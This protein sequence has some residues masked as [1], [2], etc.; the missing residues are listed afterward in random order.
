MNNTVTIT[1]PKGTVSKMVERRKSGDAGCVGDESIF[2][3]WIRRY[4][5]ARDDILFT[6]MI[7]DLPLYSFF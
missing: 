5:M 4:S 1:S 6:W 7:D 2:G 3:E